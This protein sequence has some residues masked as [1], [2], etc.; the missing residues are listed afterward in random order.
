[1]RFLACVL[2]SA[3][4]ATNA[5]A[6]TTVSQHGITWT[7]STDRVTGQFANGD[8]WVVGPVTITSI[9]PAP[10]GGL[11]GYM[12]NP[13]V[14][15]F[16]QFD[17][18]IRNHGG[19]HYAA[20]DPL[21]RTVAPGS[22]VLSS[23]SLAA[24]ATG[25]N[26]QLSTIAIL[27]VLA[28]AP[29]A[30]S[31]RPAY[32]GTDKTVRWAETDLDYDVLRSLAPAGNDRNLATVAGYFSMPWIEIDTTWTGRY[33][34]PTLNQPTGNYG[35]EISYTIADGLLLLQ[36]DY[37]NAQKRD[38]FVR[39]VQYGIDIHGAAVAGANWICDGG[40]NMGR[41][42]PLLLAGMALHDND[43]L[44]YA[45]ATAR[46]IFQEDQQTWVVTQDDVGRPLAVPP[47]DS[48]RPHE[49]YIQSD[50]GLP[51]WGIRHSREPELDGRNWNAYYR[52]VNG[53]PMTGIIL[54]ARLM[55]METAWKWPPL[56]DYVD[57]Y[58]TIEGP[59][60]R[61][62]TN[63][64]HAFPAAMWRAY[65][66]GSGPTPSRV[67]LP[68]VSPAGGAFLEPV[69][70][71]L[72]CD[73]QD[74]VIRYTTDGLTPTST[75]TLYAGPF[76][77][78]TS[79]TVKALATKP[80]LT[81][82]N[83]RDATFAIDDFGSTADIWLNLPFPPR[84]A[85][86]TVEFDMST[87]EEGAVDCLTGLALDPAQTFTDLAAI[88]RFST[89]GVVDA[90][91]GS[92]YAAENVLSYAPSVVYR[93][94]LDIDPPA[95]VY[96]VAVTPSGGSRVVIGTGFSFRTE[97]AATATLDTLAL[98]AVTGSHRVRNVTFF[99]PATDTTAPVISAL[100]T[101]VTQ[102]SATITWTTDEPATS[103]VDHGPDTSY[104]TSTTAPGLVTNH[105]VTLTGL[106]PQTPYHFRV[107][108]A[109]AVG[110]TATSADGQ[111]TTSTGVVEPVDGG[112]RDGSVPPADAGRSDGSVTSTD[113][114]RTD[115]TVASPDAGNTD[116]SVADAD[117]ATMDTD[118]GMDAPQR[119]G[120]SAGTA[121]L[122]P[123]SV[124]LLPF[125]VVTRRSRRPAGKRTSH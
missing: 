2:A 58:W 47:A 38:L 120:C 30:G 78:A 124:L 11:N 98:T 125:L 42:A 109:D 3:L 68:V 103:V 70:V 104:G 89:A 123:W 102:D 1:M 56:F 112:A 33:M 12:V 10:A 73:T 15:V 90:R 121:V 88:V 99:S 37:T 32:L 111:F 86:F 26:S 63:E 13:A 97:Q 23:I 34:H 122:P 24:A 16:Q 75:S 118:E 74:A 96:D 46:F 20:P 81:D 53:A 64:I 4:L 82:S 45:D 40:H 22:S 8:W 110:N 25:D 51:E 19:A 77:V 39:M 87:E 79:L 55:G 67:A 14:G 44:A 17:S 50:V 119:C 59:E 76:S 83:L 21:P 101:T 6:A 54:A 7:F 116:G 69:T 93:V 115:G 117:A 80:G 84:N 107:H 65:R 5:H 48:G 114:G 60:A 49:P 105:A 18:R 61:N 91:N 71:T 43:I 113:A 100:H 35:R 85:P 106:S 31:F 66:N 108:A 41:K 62:S 72:S 27:T 28:T 57:R 94:R 29:P 92:A 52:T 9:T 36:L 95:H